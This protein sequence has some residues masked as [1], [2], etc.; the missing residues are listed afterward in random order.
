MVHFHPRWEPRQSVTAGQIAFAGC[1]RA[2]LKTHSVRYTR[3]SARLRNL[4]SG[5]LRLVLRATGVNSAGTSKTNDYTGECQSLLRDRCHPVVEVSMHKFALLALGCLTLVAFGQTP[6]SLPHTVRYH[7]G[8]NSQWADPAF[9]DSS[10]PVAQDGLVPSRSRA[11]N[12][13]LWVRIRVPVPNN[14]NGPLA[15]HLDRLGVQPMAWQLFVNGQPRGGHGAFP[16]H[17]DP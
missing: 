1:I 16:P 17:A 8:D 12:R 14:L 3:R 2:K 6:S 13:F 7:F 11:T 15:L 10:W 9:D 5:R 4:R